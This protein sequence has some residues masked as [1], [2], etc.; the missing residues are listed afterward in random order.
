MLPICESNHLRWFLSHRNILWWR[1]PNRQPRSQ[2]LFVLFP[3]VRHPAPARGLTSSRPVVGVPGGGPS[4]S[5][6][7]PVAAR[8]AHLFCPAGGPSG[9]SVAGGAA[10]RGGGGSS[11]P[12]GVGDLSFK[13]PGCLAQTTGEAELKDTCDG[14][15][16]M[17]LYETC[18]QCLMAQV[19][20][21]RAQY[22]ELQQSH[23][24]LSQAVASAAGTSQ[25]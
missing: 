24:E 16:C 4:S 13:Y 11:P 18:I 20:D 10:G 1:N 25:S 6:G 21:L 8:P 7:A 22:L 5:R 9:P 23:Q 2:T 12:R 14:P 15:R 17:V 3:L 19:Q